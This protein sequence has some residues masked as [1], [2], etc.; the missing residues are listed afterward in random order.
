[1]KTINSIISNSAIGSMNN[2]YRYAV[3]FLFSGILF[4]AFSLLIFML[5]NIEYV[6]AQFNF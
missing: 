4:T 5:N 6:S 3:L 1:M 2:T